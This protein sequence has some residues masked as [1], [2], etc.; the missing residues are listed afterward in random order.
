M[1]INEL[2]GRVNGEIVGGRLLALVNGKKVY[3]TGV[4]DDGKP[5]LNEV[6]LKISNELS[7]QPPAPA[8]AEESVAKRGRRKAEALLVEPEQLELDI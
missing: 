8:A 2:A 1:D 5:F 7:F 3:L 6:G 4:G